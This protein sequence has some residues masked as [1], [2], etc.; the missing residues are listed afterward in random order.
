VKPG[1]SHSRSRPTPPTRSLKGRDLEAIY[2]FARRLRAELG[3][4]VEEVRLLGHRALDVPPEACAPLPRPSAG[5]LGPQDRRRR[6]LR[7][8]P[9]PP[10]ELLLAVR[11]RRRDVVIEDRLDELASRISRELG[12]VVAPVAYRADEW[13]EALAGTRLGETFAAGERLDM[14]AGGAGR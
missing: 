11:L 1:A 14:S 2:T 13:E 6:L 3:D 8:L 7:P 9:L 12:T 4:D 5:P 10:S